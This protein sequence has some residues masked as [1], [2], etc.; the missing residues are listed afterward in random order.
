MNRPS[1]DTAKIELDDPNLKFLSEKY[2]ALTRLREKEQ[3]NLNN[4]D[5]NDNA[6]TKEVITS[7]YKGMPPRRN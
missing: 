4:M 5:M 7:K 2:N 6:S 1:L 3:S